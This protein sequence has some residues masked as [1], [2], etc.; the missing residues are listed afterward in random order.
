MKTNQNEKINTSVCKRKQV[1][2]INTDR[3]INKFFTANIARTISACVGWKSI[4]CRCAS[5][6]KI[7]VNFMQIKQ[8]ISSA[9]R[10]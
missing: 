7:T 3:M 9:N 8:L 1:K 2:A 4:L 10:S 6:K 5:M